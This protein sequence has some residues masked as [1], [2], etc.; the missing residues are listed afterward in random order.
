[1]AR[2]N[3]AGD[4]TPDTVEYDGPAGG[5]G[6]LKGI[7]RIFGKE[8]DSPAALNT[9]RRQNKPKGFMCVSCSWAKPADY[10]AFEFCE[11]G[12]K[13]T[14][15]E[16]TSRR[17]TPDFFAEHTVTEL[18]S[19]SDYDLEQQGRLTHP[20]RYDST[21]DKYV[22]CSWDEAFHAIG[23]QLR[24]LD[25]KSVVFYSS[26]RAS[27]ETSY[28]YALFAR[29]YGTNNLPDSSNMCHET[30]SV[31]L[32]KLIGAGVGTVV[33]DDLS[34]CDAMFFFG[35]NTGSNSPRFLHPLQDAAKRGVQIIT[36][37]PVREKGLE[38]FIN[39]QNPT[40][41]LTGKATQIS[42]QYHQVKVGG[43]IAVIVGICKHVFAADD[44]AKQQGKR[45]IDAPFVGQHTHGFEEFEAR[46]RATS[47]DEIEIASGLSRSVIEGAA[48]VYVEADRVIGIYGMGLTQHVHG[49]QNVAM[50]VNMLLLKG[51]IGR[52]GTGIS[53]V[54]GH[55]NVQGQRTV[56]ISEKPELVPLDKYAKQ[57]GFEPP[58]EKGMNTVET[59][60]GVLAGK[61]KAFVGL[62]G[63]FV[64]AIP[65]RSKM[66]AAWRGLE[67]TVQIA[68]TLNRSHLVHGKAAY[69]LPCLG[70]TEEDVQASGQQAVTMEDTFSCIQG[71]IGLRKPA[72]EHLRSEVAIVA[73][74]AKATLPPNPKLKWD[75]WVGNYDLIRNEIAE[76]YPDEFHDFNARMFT[77]GGFYRG[78]SARERIWKTE[79]GKA[80]FTAPE[81]LTST[82][83]SDAPGRFRL[84]TMR[85]ND[86]FN[87]TIYG[88]SD[89]MRGIEGTREVLLMNPD[90]IARAGLQ[91]GQMVSLVSDAEDGILRE[92]GP[93]K[94]TPFKLPDGCVGAYYP[95]MNPLIPLSH[96]DI[97]SKTPAAKSV[98]VRIRA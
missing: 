31:A 24:A 23:S 35:Q 70:R 22:P 41:M 29:A 21:T 13:A 17:C 72:S 94:V 30:T 8:W 65:E 78:N 45:V 59:C 95:E 27:L 14:L 2:P 48:Q 36:F 77:P 61:V 6:S 52:D 34:N 91:E 37:N 66:E 81:T 90:E 88:Y 75:E 32:K 79:S 68:T 50:L 44:A 86:Q 3:E 69:L 16:L 42:S 73:G 12:A 89:R 67:L 84:L 43:D 5:W 97:H 57:F 87:T 38:V 56:G 98:P 26:G 62:G 85:S 15:W 49:F 82:G 25:P 51:N 9:L 93:L 96:H 80:E 64:R 19:W 18:L 55:S 54:R 58:R 40:E 53:P 46:V 28:L 10:H 20:L 92:V 33:F 39:P 60:E 11:N 47:W 4:H 76:T 7:A 74:L 71:S 1:M 63:N 83:F